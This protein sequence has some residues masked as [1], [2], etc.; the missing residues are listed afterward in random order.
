MLSNVHCCADK[1]K[2]NLAHSLT[3]CGFVGVIPFMPKHVPLR[4]PW[5]I[6]FLTNFFRYPESY[7]Q[8]VE[9]KISVDYNIHIYACTHM[10]L[11][12]RSMLSIMSARADKGKPAFSW[13]M[14]PESL[15]ASLASYIKTVAVSQRLPL[16]HTYPVF[17]HV[18][19][20]AFRFKNVCVRTDRRSHAYQRHGCMQVCLHES[21]ESLTY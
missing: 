8:F 20:V 14:Q 17:T 5:S 15:K 10:H 3:N 16:V 13:G 12:L 4:G 2:W 21:A 19:M 1:W 7:I 18:C 6:Q 9:Q 11:V